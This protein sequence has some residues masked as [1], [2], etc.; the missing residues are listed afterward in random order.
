MY[1]ANVEGPAVS[2]VKHE[3]LAGR[4]LLVVRPSNADGEPV[5]ES[6]VAIDTVDAGL[7][8]TALVMREGRSAAALVG[9]E[10]I[11][12]RTLIVGIVDRVDA[13]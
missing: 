13:K 3:V 2:N 6:M 11:P 9:K 4:K 10:Y 1:I 7:G 5:G 8:D 12:V